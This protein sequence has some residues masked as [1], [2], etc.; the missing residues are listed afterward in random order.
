M[1]ADSENGCAGI[2]NLAAVFFFPVFMYLFRLGV[3]GAAISS[4]LSQYVFFLIIIIVTINISPSV[5]Q[6]KR[7]NPCWDAAK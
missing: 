1:L 7:H 4:I 2:G 6:I 5:S 3:T